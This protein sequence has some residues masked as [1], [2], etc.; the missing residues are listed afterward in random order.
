VEH[1]RREAFLEEYRRMLTANGI[2]FDERY[3]A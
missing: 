3:L 2:Q 1:H